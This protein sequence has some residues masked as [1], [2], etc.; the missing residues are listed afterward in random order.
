MGVAVETA[1]VLLVCTGNQSRS[2][3]A[4]ALLR[5]RLRGSGVGAEIWSAGTAAREGAV[6]HP[7][8]ADALARYGVTV[9]SHRPRRLL[10][11][12]VRGADLVLCAE[13]MHRLQVAR[14]D[15]TAV[16][17]TF[18]LAEFGR[19]APHLEG[20]SLQELL[21]LAREQRSTYPPRQ[22]SDDDIPDPVR[23][24]HRMHEQIV[25]RLAGLTAVVAAVLTLV[26]GPPSSAPGP[27]AAGHDREPHLPSP[28]APAFTSAFG[29][30]VTVPAAPATG[31]VWSGPER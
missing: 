10:V 4:E 21:T 28:P 17:K 26:S 9:R 23:G 19:I 8:T 31:W 18:T 11:D 29:S 14:L 20:G 6:L 2:P 27:T 13:R 5:Q 12:D 3:A 1:R 24:D 16:G 15:S 25:T 22:P 30:A 7:L